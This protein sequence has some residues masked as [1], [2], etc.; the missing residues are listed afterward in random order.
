MR[1]DSDVDSS[2]RIAAYLD[3]LSQLRPLVSI[4]RFGSAAKQAFVADTS[5]VDLFLVMP[6]EATAEDRERLRRQVAE[7]E[8]AHGFRLPDGPLKNPFVK[9]VE[10]AAVHAM[11]TFIFRRADLLSGD[12]ARIFD[13][14]PAE[15]IFVDRILLP[16]IIVSARTVWGEDLLHRVPLPPLRRLDIAKAL[17][18]FVNVIVM[19]TVAYRILP[20]A[21][22]YAMGVL[23]HSLHNCYCCYRHE[24]AAVDEEIAFFEAK[25]GPCP[26][27]QDLLARRRRYQP[28]I[29]FVLRCLPVLLRLHLLTA[30][31]SAFPSIVK[32]PAQ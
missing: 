31:E 14:R 29:R 13:L 3:Q 2:T 16:S 28:S 5:D 17:F 1:Y 15:A 7:L 23:K 25:L 12:V 6:D 9:F 21:T 10:R 4:I 20:D 8:I 30:R 32:R 18:Q 27:L 22:R 11:S 26:I 19:S 24:N